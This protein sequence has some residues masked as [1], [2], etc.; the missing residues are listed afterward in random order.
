MLS[1]VTVCSANG[2]AED[3]SPSPAVQAIQPMD[4]SS[5]YTGRYD[6]KQAA[7]IVLLKDTH[8][9]DIGDSRNI[10]DE[11]EKYK[12]KDRHENRH[13]DND[14]YKDEDNNKDK[15]K[16][17]DRYKD[18]D[19]NIDKYKDGDK[20]RDKDN[21]KDKYKNSD[22]YQDKDRNRD[23]YNDGDKYK[24]K[25]RNRDKYNGRHPKRMPAPDKVNRIPDNNE[26][27]HD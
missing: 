21:N 22:K 3:S 15:Y 7:P 27:N 9:H 19:S 26:S 10:D 6:G 8:S 2:L 23:K 14:R 17:G 11:K 4:L 18:K 12:N 1:A 16:D 25:D 5:N 20:Y 24:D 13:K